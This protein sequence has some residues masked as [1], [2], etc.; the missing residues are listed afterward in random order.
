VPVAFG[1]KGAPP[2]NFATLWAIE[3]TWSLTYK[4]WGAHT[5]EIWEGQKVENS[6]WFRT[7]F[8]YDREYLKNRSRYQNLET[9]LIKHDFYG[10]LKKFSKVW[11]TKKK[12]QARMLIH[13]KSSLHIWHILMRWSSGHV[14]LLP[15][16]FQP[17]K[18]FLR[19]GLMAP[20]GL[21]LGLAQNF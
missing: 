12:L 10:I 19:I 3:W 9:H 16:E 11:S 6:A 2:W 17:P 15:G 5:P 21:T 4:F 13:P 20:G 18:F 7:T 8:D 14:T 1:V